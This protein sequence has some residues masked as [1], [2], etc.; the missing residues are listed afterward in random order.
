MIAGAEYDKIKLPGNFTAV[1][2]NPMAS[3]T[4]RDKVMI[5][6][7]DNSPEYQ[8]IPAT[9]EA[10]YDCPKDLMASKPVTPYDNPKDLMK[11]AGY[12]EPTNPGEFI[13]MNQTFPLAYFLHRK[14]GIF[15]VPNH[16]HVSRPVTSYWNH[17]AMT[18]RDCSLH[19]SKHIF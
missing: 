11:Q 10:L 17:S 16:C 13:S 5:D 1:Y 6:F 4:S 12:Q 8:Q 14:S 15:A 19:L 9:K 2:D 18:C 3:P 7:N